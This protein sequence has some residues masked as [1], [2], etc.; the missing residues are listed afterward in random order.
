MAELGPCCFLEMRLRGRWF[1]LQALRR[2]AGVSGENKAERHGGTAPAAC[3]Q[4]LP[5]VQL[6]ARSPHPQPARL[7]SWPT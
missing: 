7:L 4:P 5:R 3:G 6:P 2:Q 1:V